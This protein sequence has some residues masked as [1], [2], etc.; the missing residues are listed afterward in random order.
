[1]QSN[2]AQRLGQ[3]EF[4]RAVGHF[5]SGVTV[6][7]A[8]RD[9]QQFGATISA[10]SSLSAEP[11]MVLVCLNQ[12]LG[13]H[14]AIEASGRFTINILGE[15]QGGMAL[16]FATAG[17]DKFRDV[18]WSATDHGARLTDAIAHLSCRVV[19]DVEGGTHRVFVAEVTEART[20]S[21]RGPLSYFC[22]RFG[23]FVE[24][25]EAS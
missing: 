10:V 1:M 21:G 7:T 5:A 11:P 4:R 16:A 9:G 24:H 12:R 8:E 6:V 14:A 18:A 25:E 2:G 20:G 19:D 3:A 23:R 15:G 17:A 22:G 13:T